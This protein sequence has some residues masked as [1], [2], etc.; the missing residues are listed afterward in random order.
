MATLDKRPFSNDY[1]GLLNQSVFTVCIAGICI[2]SHD[3]MKRKRRG[4][5]VEGLGSV[6][7]W[8]FGYLYQGRCWARNPSPPI[9][10]G[11]P[12]SWVKQVISFPEDKLNE[13]RGPDATV[14]SR[15]LRGCTR[16]VLLHTF[17]T[18]P[19]LLPIHLHF[20]DGTVSPHS[21]ARASISSLVETPAGRSLLWI[22]VILLYYVTLSWI[23]TLIWICRGAFRHRHAQIQRAAERAASAAQTPKDLQYHPHP[24]P[25]YPFHSL[26][27]L[28]DDESNRGLRLRTIMV[29][30]VPLHLRSEKELADY[31]ECHLSR[32]SVNPVTALYPRHGFFN[33]V[34]AVIYDHIKRLFEHIEHFHY[35]ESPDEDAIHGELEASTSKAPVI[36]C[37]IIARKM[38]ELAHLLERREEVLQRLEAAHVKLAQK[39]LNAVKQ[40]LDKRE[41]CRRPRI[42]CLSL[43]KR[44]GDE[45]IPLDMAVDDEKDREQLVR[46]L[47]PFV[48]EFGLRSGSATANPC[49][50][51]IWEAL[52]T[53]PRNALNRYQPLIRLSFHGHTTSEIDYFTEKFNLLTTLI[54]KNRARGI[55]SYA[56][57]ST[58]FV[59]FSDPKDARRACQYLASHPDNP[60]NCVIQ[61]AP[62]YEDLDWKRIMKSTFKAEFIKDWVVNIG[63]WVFTL[64]W[65]FPVSLFVGLVSIQNI[66]AFWPSLAKYLAHHT[67][68]EEFLRSF[69]PTFLTSLLAFLMPLIL[70][71]IAKKAHTII[72]LSALH[73][74]TMTRYWKFLAINIL[75]FFCIGTVALQ[76][77]LVGFGV[78]PDKNV[79]HILSDS[80][81]TAGPFYVGWLIFTTG[82]HG[83]VELALFGLPLIM[84]PSTKRAITPRKR[85]VGI[86]PRTFNYH[87]WLPNHLLVIHILVLF[88]VFNPLVMPFGLIYF[89]IQQVVIKNQLLRVYAKNYEGNGQTI[90]IRIIRYSL[91][92]MVFGQ[93]VFLAYMAV[94]RKNANLV[95]AAVLIAS[96]AL[97]K[98][99]MTRV[100]RAKFER[101]DVNE[102]MIIC[103][104]QRG[105]PRGV[106][107]HINHDSKIG[108][109]KAD[110]EQGPVKSSQTCE[111]WHLPQVLPHSTP[112]PRADCNTLDT[113]I[114]FENTDNVYSP[115][116]SEFPRVTEHHAGS[117]VDDT[118]LNDVKRTSSDPLVSPRPPHPR[119]DDESD[120]NQ[121]Y[122][123]PYYTKPIGHSLWL[124]RNPCD[125]LD[126]D[127]TI[128][129]GKALTS[130][131]M[132][133]DLRP[134]PV[135][136]QSSLLSRKPS[137][138]QPSP[139]HGSPASMPSTPLEAT[140]GLTDTVSRHLSS[141]E[142]TVLPP[143][144]E[145]RIHS[146]D[147]EMISQPEPRP[148]SHGRRGS[149]H[150]LSR[151]TAINTTTSM[152]RSRLESVQLEGRPHFGPSTRSVSLPIGGWLQRSTSLDPKLAE[153]A[154]ILPDAQAQIELLTSLQLQ[155]REDVAGSSTMSPIEAVTQEVIIEE[156]AVAE[157]RVRQEEEEAERNTR[158]HPWWM[159]WFFSRAAT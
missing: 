122:D 2:I 8:E 150:N 4:N 145:S 91:D 59:T 34:A 146:I 140:H 73:D 39:V 18:V 83:G 67:W 152:T 127:D 156:R 111:T 61:M 11:W 99:I 148:S 77:L 89:S 153:V 33:K 20:S 74:R 136:S 137:D 17:T 100:C 64:A 94:W 84:Y 116:R 86:R 120:P 46:T 56:P 14:Y 65:I 37:V 141:K 43:F 57:V 69:L 134:R 129:L 47:Q 115:I 117:I 26:P 113:P 25:Q 119:W 159:R 90:L 114:P 107:A 102:A 81:P 135:G 15:F 48:E 63:V 60:I 40:E 87:Y 118:E 79:L 93:A 147:V 105:Q 58:A 92:G 121:P 44:R 98:L 138:A 143:R 97:T 24:H 75:V 131:A 31:F 78:K 36:S 1:S 41:G 70:L 28:D 51:T 103:G 80:F 110:V 7:S 95:L 144:M 72:T 133:G 29:T 38:T 50:E 128:D 85:N 27:V 106:T 76:S 5:K 101:D 155:P 42:R 21:M 149:A 19:I 157:E 142:E 66:S 54:A 35:A 3:I 45:E 13:L 88:A 123:N 151:P 112:P 96:T 71:F 68:E 55:E 82:I 154:G 130:T 158:E 9:P 52:H 125:L 22:H 109:D 49:L 132:P 62:S 30:N 104:L 53:L 23:A 10:Q 124:P 6:E 126:L 108:I 32:P 139:L 12:L 16:F